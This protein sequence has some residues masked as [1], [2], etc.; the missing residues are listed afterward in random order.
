MPT[1]FKVRVLF[2]SPI[3][4]VEGNL[5]VDIWYFS[6]DGDMDYFE[7][8]SRDVITALTEPERQWVSLEYESLVLMRIRERYI[9]IYHQLQG[10][11]NMDERKLLLE[12]SHTLLNGLD[13]KQLKKSEK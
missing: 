9:E 2:C 6:S 4:S 10:L 3:T 11:K 1:S 8:M 7:Y 5:T 12:E 13:Q